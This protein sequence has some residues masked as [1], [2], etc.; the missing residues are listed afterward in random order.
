MAGPFLFGA[1][2][3]NIDPDLQLVE[4]YSRTVEVVFFIGKRL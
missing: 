4:I 1:Y 3:E 2:Y